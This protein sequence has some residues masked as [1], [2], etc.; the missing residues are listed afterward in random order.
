MNDRR[1]F[2]HGVCE[3]LFFHVPPQGKRSANALGYRQH[4]LWHS[5]L[6]VHEG[7]DD[8]AE[9]RIVSKSYLANAEKFQK[10]T[11]KSARFDQSLGINPSE[12]M[13]RRRPSDQQL[14]RACQVT[15]VQPE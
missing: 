5:A 13:P 10:K 8:I 6:D 2:S 15:L 14:Q 12:M 9:A 4:H 7:Q 1:P 3:T 11:A